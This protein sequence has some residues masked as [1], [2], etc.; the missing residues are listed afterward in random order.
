MHR[1]ISQYLV[2]LD[3]WTRIWSVFQKALLPPVPGLADSK[4]G[5]VTAASCHPLLPCA[6]METAEVVLASLNSA[7][8]FCLLQTRENV[9]HEHIAP[10]LAQTFLRG[11]RWGLRPAATLVGSSSSSLGATVMLTAATLPGPLTLF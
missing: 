6:L 8:D 9:E 10:Q 1:Q 11:G 5:V 2:K 3:K 4:F 7:P